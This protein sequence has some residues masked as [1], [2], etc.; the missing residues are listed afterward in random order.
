MIPLRKK[1]TKFS[2]KRFEIKTDDSAQKAIDALIKH[3]QSS[4]NKNAP[5]LHGILFIARGIAV[6]GSA[7]TNI[8]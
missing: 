3:Y 4:S 1:F 6:D 5:W 7:D 8:H 2:L